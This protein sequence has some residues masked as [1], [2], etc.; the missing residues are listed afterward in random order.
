MHC[1]FF[2]DGDMALL[3][4]PG[5]L[6]WFASNMTMYMWARKENG[7]A[8]SVLSWLGLPEHGWLIL[9]SPGWLCISLAGFV[10]TLLAMVGYGWI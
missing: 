9:V 3:G 10:L 5:W 6:A 7:L 4:R 2:L 8:E 1:L